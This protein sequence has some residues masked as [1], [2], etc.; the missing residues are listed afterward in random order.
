MLSPKG[1]WLSHNFTQTSHESEPMTS[2]S[3]VRCGEGWLHTATPNITTDTGQR[4]KVHIHSR[5]WG[6]WNNH[7]LSIVL[8]GKAASI[9][10]TCSLCLSWLWTALTNKDMISPH[11]GQEIWD[12]TRSTGISGYT[13]WGIKN[14]HKR[15]A[16]WKCC[17]WVNILIRTGWTW[18]G[19]CFAHVQLCTNT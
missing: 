14:T 16:G 19:S 3:Y 7:E 11:L 18:V 15:F 13:R 5:L 8:L 17:R 4:G 10:G 12:Y 2:G 6:G 1:D 9:E